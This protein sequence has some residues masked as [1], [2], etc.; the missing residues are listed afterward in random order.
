MIT[1]L[2]SPF[3]NPSC[4]VTSWTGL[5][6]TKRGGNEQIVAVFS[7]SLAASGK[8]RVKVNRELQLSDRA[9]I[10]RTLAI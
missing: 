6:G 8:T 7:F 9:V 5:L 3:S 4:F 2:H 1:S 10:A